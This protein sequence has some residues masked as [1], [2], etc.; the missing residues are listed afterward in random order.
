MNAE[1][2]TETYLGNVQKLQDEIQAYPTDDSLWKVK[3][4]ISNSGGNLC[5]HLMGSLQHFIGA[6]IG[7]NGYI[8]DREKEF[9]DKGLSKQ[10]LIILIRKTQAVL[11]SVLVDLTDV[12]LA[13]EYP[14]DF[15]GKRSTGWYLNHFLMHLQYH[16]GQ[17]NY[18]RRLM[19]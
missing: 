14:F 2:Y 4:G 13:K 17:I 8:R 1:Y 11:Q 6:T 19:A 16:L 5:L 18:H 15:L 7:H 10:E 3:E 9:S 12:E